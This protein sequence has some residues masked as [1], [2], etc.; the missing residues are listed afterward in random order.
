MIL[1]Y[2]KPVEI[3]P[4]SVYDNDL[5]KEYIRDLKDDYDK[6]REEQ[7]QLMDTYGS[8][9]TSLPG[10]QQAFYDATIGPIDKMYDTYG[11]DMLRDPSKRAML[12]QYAAKAAAAAR[13]IKQ[14]AA[15]YDA[16]KAQYDKLTPEQ[17]AYEDYM[18]GQ[19]G[20]AQQWD[21][22]HP[23]TKTSPD[24]YRTPKEYF[25]PTLGKL[26]QNSRKDG[27][28]WYY[29]VPEE[30]VKDQLALEWGDYTN[31]PEYQYDVQ[32]RANR[33][34]QNDPTLTPEQAVQKASED[35][36]K[37]IVSQY[38]TEKM[39]GMDPSVLARIKGSYGRSYSRG[40][41]GRRSSG[42]DYTEYEPRDDFFDG[43]YADAIGSV[44][45]IN[46]SWDTQSQIDDGTITAK[47]IIDKQVQ[48]AGS[49][50]TATGIMRGMTTSLGD[51]NDDDLADAWN[52]T[53]NEDGTLYVD[54]G[55]K[56]RL[57]SASQVFKEMKGVKGRYPGGTYDQKSL[58][59]T[60]NALVYYGKRDNI[61]H[62]VL[63]FVDS[64]G[65]KAYL[66]GGLGSVRNDAKQINKAGSAAR[67]KNRVGTERRNLKLST[68]KWQK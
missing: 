61:I 54:D 24:K 42:G 5:F 53:S 50:K 3:A 29:G 38:T 47:T 8:F 7:K 41:G 27:D 66:Y 37:E 55:V 22:A 33:E 28:Y 39:T 14:A 10:A 2:E 20:L 43:V 25:D 9:M 30:A 56:N 60:H 34:M 18:L 58:Q 6:T 36:Q 23:W 63:E 13:P 49:E 19:Q 4:M 67:Y 31:T 51:Y 40:G 32:N 15:I 35:M 44:L 65:R 12:R 59:P 62:L 11:G 64:H 46:D 52:F 45:G 21:P 1:G 68:A 57:R 48:L 26:P 16:Y 17:R